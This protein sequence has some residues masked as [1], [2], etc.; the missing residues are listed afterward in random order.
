MITDAPPRTRT[1]RILI[2]GSRAWPWPA[3]IAR[4][5][6]AE[7]DRL[8][9]DTTLTVIHGACPDGADAAA[10]AWCAQAKDTPGSDVVEDPH[11]AHWQDQDGHLDRA[12]GTVRDGEM[13]GSG[14]D[15]VIAFWADHSA[16]TANTLKHAAQARIPAVV[17][18]AY[19]SPLPPA[20][21]ETTTTS[22][23]PAE[24]AAPA[25]ARRR[26]GAR[27]ATA[28]GGRRPRKPTADEQADQQI[29]QGY[30]LTQNPV[31]Q[32][33]HEQKSLSGQCACG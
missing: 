16:G 33:C 28:G 17:Y 4:V 2:T 26:T 25:P 11:P 9:A 23:G 27:R 8:P 22:D 32:T 19:S 10:A 12:A 6:D 7:R 24:A 18:T 29:S 13:V 31:C 14:A 30:T 15:L 20:A 5:L 1:R 3:H 21:P